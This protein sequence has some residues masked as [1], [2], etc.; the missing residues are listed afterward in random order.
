MPRWLPVAG[1]VYIVVSAALP[2]G[3]YVAAS[4]YVLQVVLLAV[5]GW[6]G[7]RAALDRR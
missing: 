3:P 6:Y 2:A 1:I 4:G 7:L 5:I